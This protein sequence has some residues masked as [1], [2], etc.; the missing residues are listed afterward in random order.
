MKRINQTAVSDFCD[1]L[2][3]PSKLDMYQSMV[4]ALQLVNRSYVQFVA[5]DDFPI[6]STSQK[7]CDILDS[8]ALISYAI[9]KFEYLSTGI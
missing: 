4:V 5:D 3:V 1:Y 2:S 6:L 7:L 9:G 8:D